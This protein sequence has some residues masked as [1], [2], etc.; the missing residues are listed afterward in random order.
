MVKAG[1]SDTE[2]AETNFSAFSRT[3][4]AIDRIRFQ[5]RPV[6][7]VG[8]DII[9]CVGL[10]GLG[11]THWAYQTYPDLFE[12]AIGSSV[13]F[14]GYFGQPV[15]LL[16][17]FEGDMPLASA[18]KVL[19]NYYVRMAPVKGS[20]TWWNPSTIVVTSNSHPSLWYDY[21]KRLSKESAL[22]RRFTVIREYTAQGVVVHDTPDA[23]A[24]YWPIVSGPVV[25]QE[26]KNNYLQL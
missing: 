8:R 22:R 15:V 4:K 23:I 16:D 2:L 3:L 1:K 18:L 24:L 11:K 19:D 10:P 6:C 17:E 25:K 13:W 5:S 21:T 20:F 7:L 26:L 12:L 14:D 9:L